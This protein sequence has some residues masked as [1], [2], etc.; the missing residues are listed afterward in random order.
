MFFSSKFKSFLFFFFWSANENEYRN[1]CASCHALKFEVNLTT[2]KLHEL[3]Y[4]QKH[5]S[6]LALQEVKKMAHGMISVTQL[7][8]DPFLTHDSYSF[9]TLDVCYNP[10]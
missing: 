1:I 5:M 2:V 9:L 7:N 3:N 6:P 8:Q 10:L 4:G